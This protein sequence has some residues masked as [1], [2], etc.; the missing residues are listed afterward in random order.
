[1][2]SPFYLLIWWYYCL[3]EEQNID[4]PICVLFGVLR[5]SMT[6]STKTIWIGHQYKTDTDWIITGPG[7]SFSGLCKA[8]K[9]LYTSEDWACYWRIVK[10]Y[11]CAGYIYII[12]LLREDKTYKCVHLWCR[13][14]SCCSSKDGNSCVINGKFMSAECRPFSDWEMFVDLSISFLNLHWMILN[15]EGFT[16]SSGSAGFVMEL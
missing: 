2:A 11:L 5:F 7:I 4:S 14:D 12:Y 8:L 1:M 16:G 15:M 6:R 13:K 3:E 9:R 10:L